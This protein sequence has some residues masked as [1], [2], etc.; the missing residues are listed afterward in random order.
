MTDAERD[1]RIDTLTDAI[2]D[3]NRAV[4]ALAVNGERTESNVTKLTAN[5]DGLMWIMRQHLIVDHG[6]PEPEDDTDE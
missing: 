2:A 1:A 4:M 3:T 6:Y 5:V